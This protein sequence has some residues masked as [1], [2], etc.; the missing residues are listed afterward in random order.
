MS[1]LDQRIEVVTVSLRPGFG[2]VV[3]LCCGFAMMLAL[4]SPLSAGRF[5]DAV[6]RCLSRLFV[7][8]R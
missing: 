5:V 2:L 1:K 8:I 7:R 3:K 4:F 6:I